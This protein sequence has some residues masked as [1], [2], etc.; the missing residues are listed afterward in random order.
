MGKQKDF[1]IDWLEDI[2]YELGYDL[3]NYHEV[4]KLTVIEYLRDAYILKDSNKEQ[5]IIKMER[6]EKIRSIVRSEIENAKKDDKSEENNALIK[7]LSDFTEHETK[8]QLEE[9]K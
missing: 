9:K 5:E 3:Q 8:K 1:L 2:G 4:D 7:H 6:E